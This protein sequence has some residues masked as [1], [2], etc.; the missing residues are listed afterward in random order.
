MKVKY[1]DLSVKDEKMK[2]ELLQAIDKILSKGQIMLGPEVEIFE[3]QVADFCK[4]KYAVG[5]GSGTMSLFMA[6]RALDIGEG[7]EVITTPLSWIATLNAIILTGAKPIFVDVNKDFNIN[8]CL[9]EDA[10]TSKTKCILPVHFMGKICNMPEIMKIANKHNLFVIED[11]AQAFGASIDGKMA[12]AFGHLGCFSMNPMKIFSAY[13]EAGLILTDDKKMYE[14]ILSMRYLGTVNRG[15]CLYT[16]LN[17]KIDTIQAAILNIKFKYLE[18]RIKK[19]QEIAKFYN[20]ALK[21][22]VTC[23][24]TETSEHVYLSYTIL[25]PKRNELMEFLTSNDIET[26]IQYPVL[27]PNHSAYKGKYK[28]N[29][30]VA[31]QLADQMLSLPNQDYITMDEASYVADKVIQFFN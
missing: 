22:I 27:M 20:N 8:T 21:D 14:K 16:S 1:R 10:I 4:K 15:D 5:I 13:G 28:F 29:A 18:D 23:P 30:P 6:L 24:L 19:S 17:G 31:K 12:G 11:S 2:N 25:T 9:I 3:N 7:D 26:K